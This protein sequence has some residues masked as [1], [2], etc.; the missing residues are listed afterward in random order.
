MRAKAAR[1]LARLGDR[2][3]IG[4]LIALFKD[5]SDTV[6]ENAIKALAETGASEAAEA[7]MAIA[8]SPEE[9]SE[10]RSQSIRALGRMRVQEAKTLLRTLRDQQED[11][12]VHEAASEAVADMDDSK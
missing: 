7:L 10:V 6:R 5:D 12:D 1:S 2:R 11:E 9:S 4:P 8:A 3:A